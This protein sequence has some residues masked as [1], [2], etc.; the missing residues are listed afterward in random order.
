M[1]GSS[2][3]LIY[4]S[5]VRRTSYMCVT[6]RA[7][8]GTLSTSTSISMIGSVITRRTI[9]SNLISICLTIHRVLRLSSETQAITNDVIGKRN[10]HNMDVSP[11]AG[12][13]AG[14]AGQESSS[15]QST[16]R[17][18][19]SSDSSLYPPAAP[20]DAGRRPERT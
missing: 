6:P 3:S 12:V 11:D 17:R 18:V 1:K 9:G 20:H 13:R 19:F 2:G 8:H 16:S 15:E 5:Q 10:W 14:V 7:V 4:G